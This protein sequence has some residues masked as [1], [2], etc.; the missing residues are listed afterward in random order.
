[1]W[2]GIHT[3]LAV[4]STVNKVVTA[5]RPGKSFPSVSVTG[6]EC[7]L[8]CR[9]CA[10]RYLRSMRPARSP[11]ELLSLAWS[12]E[13]EGGDGFLLSG[14]CD[15][16]GRVPL[17]PF[18]DAIRRIKKETGL[19]VNAHVGLAPKRSLESL[20]SAGVD[21]FS[22]DLHGSEKVIRQVL[23]LSA[24][25]DDFL[26]V[27]LDLESLGAPTVA[28]HVCIG[29]EPGSISSETDAI[30]LLAP[31][32]AKKL[33]LIAFTPTKGTP[34]ESLPPPAPETIVQVVRFARE[35]MPGSRL[36]LGCMRPRSLRGYEAEAVAAGVGGIAMPSNE[37]LALLRRR[38]TEVEEKPVCCAFG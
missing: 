8:G 7:A 3:I 17:D 12:L 33:V 37:T 16:A 2:I 15:A 36:L 27:V 23:G 1:M 20:V 30:R 19:L 31:T 10:G 4:F 35:R 9:H 13:Q 21:A 11:E 32:G 5:F 14:G 6:G 28:P 38:G 22:V 18:A 29:L 25:P 34:N 24:T 26:R